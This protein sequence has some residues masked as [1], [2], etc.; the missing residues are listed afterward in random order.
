MLVR[1]ARKKKASFTAEGASNPRT[2]FII[3][4]FGNS[5]ER[6]Y[7]NIF[8]PA[9]TEVGLNPVRADSLFRSSPI[10]ADIWNCVQKASV[11]L[12]DLS[13]K[14]P[15]V[16]YEL[17][18]AHAVGKP[19]VLV[20]NTID[21]VP[22]DLR[23]L[24]VII[25]DKDYDN[26]GRC[27]RNSIVKS[28]RETLA[29]FASAVPAMFLPP[30]KPQV[31]TDDPLQATL[32]RLTEEITAMRTERSPTGFVLAHPPHVLKL[33]PRSGRR[34]ITEAEIEDVRNVFAAHGI[35][36]PWSNSV[37]E[38]NGGITIALPAD[39]NPDSL[40]L[41]LAELAHRLCDADFQTLPE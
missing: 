22:F 23:G 2:C 40:T 4:P 7:G 37:R 30:A 33:M 24:R 41:I 27:L 17:G 14:N 5:F 15:N 29:D 20:A 11:I 36:L 21:D 12:A 28:L 38:R 18:L 35:H 10:V 1:M 39:A 31:T 6:Y 26:W 34:P 32:R 13:T 8:V 16:F 3:M 25:Y 9:V 19:V